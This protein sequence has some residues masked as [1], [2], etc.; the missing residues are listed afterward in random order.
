MVVKKSR[1][2][3]EES[4]DSR[5]EK[6]NRE[7]KAL[8]KTNMFLS[9]LYDGISEE[10]IVID[11]DFYIV[12]A[13]RAF[14]TKAG[15]EKKDV[16]GRRCYEIKRAWRPCLAGEERCPVEKAAT[17]EPVEIT[18]THKDENGESR[19]YIVIMYPLMAEDESRRYYLEIT[20]DV[21]EFRHLILKL[22]RSEKRFKAILD[23]ATDAII[24]IDKTRA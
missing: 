4:R 6:L 8:K 10:I 17:G 1:I 20:S 19:E 7:I 2:P 3:K 15:L 18:V 12:D 23:T 21:T 13:N 24:S 16:A 14:L 9:S 11:Q 22:Q 5:L